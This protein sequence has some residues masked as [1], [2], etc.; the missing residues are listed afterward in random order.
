MST[1]DNNKQTPL[2]VAS[3]EGHIAVVTE[4]LLRGAEVDAKNKYE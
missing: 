1:K 3:L 4:L 2:H